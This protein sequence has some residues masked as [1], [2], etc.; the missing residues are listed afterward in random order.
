MASIIDSIIGYV[1][2][3][4]GLKRARARAAMNLVQRSY[5]GAKTGRRTNGWTS[6]GNSANAEIAPALTLLRNRSRDLVRN[7]PYAKKAIS[8]YVSNAVGTGI[9]AKIDNSQ[10]Q[11]LWEK[12]IKECDADGQ[13]DFYGL[14]SL[15]ANTIKESGEVL[16]RLRYRLPSDGLS[17]PLQLQV[18]EPDYLDN[19][20]TETLRN[21][22]W[23]QNGIQFDPL[24]RREG[25]WLF[26]SHPGEISPILNSLVSVFVPASDV[27]HI[28]EKTR[29]GQSRGVPMLAASML[30]MRDLDD[31]E[32][33]ELVRKGIEACFA[34]F[35]TT[36]DDSATMGESSTES[37]TSRRLETLSAGM[38]Q[39][40]KPGEDVSFGAPS[41]SNGYNEYIRTQLH[42]IAA[43][44]GIT[45]EQ[46]T[47]DL[48]QVNYSSIRAGTLEHRR[49]VEQFQWITFIPMLCDAVM[50]A[51][52]NSA[53][54]A[55]KVKKTDVQ[56]RWTPPRWDWVDPV[57]DMTGELL[58]VAAGFKPWG[59]AVRGR[60]YSP[61]ENIAEISSEQEKFRKAGIEIMINALA[62]GAA[63]SSDKNSNQN[64][65]NAK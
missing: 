29:P 9:I 34:A 33:A 28:Y 39:Y 7:N 3:E 55:G 46:L 32:E 4:A 30:K 52:L 51:W 31:Y 57:R 13:H 2:P 16:I 44:A 24:G 11:K 26:K 12:W 27:L 25:Y 17:V 8:T 6:G 35:V 59:E 43:G 20:K 23:I 54:L 60:G 45:Y 37:D 40:L 41:A 49:S 64:Q 53:Q 21:G 48:S 14:Q 50:K 47:G 18:L 58:E 38:I 42:A 1:S 63:S 22:G 19:L 56:V 15:A 5:D 62:L 10:T 61:D 36:G 65:S